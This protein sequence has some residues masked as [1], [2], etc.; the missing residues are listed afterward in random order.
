M[1]GLILCVA[2]LLAFS[3]SA[4]EDLH[5]VGVKAGLNLSRFNH[6]NGNESD[7]KPGFNI[8]LYVKAPIAK[9]MYIRPEIYFSGQGEKKDIKPDPAGLLAEHVV[10]VNYLNLPVLL[11]AG[12]K[13]T[14]Q[15]GPQLGYLLTARQTITVD[16]ETTRQSI[17][18]TVNRFDVSGVIGIGIN[19]HESFNAGMRLNYGITDVFKTDVSSSNHVFHVYFAYTF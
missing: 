11:E 13:V 9:H 19:P 2:T 10:T 6:D 8:G 1:R 16:D 5:L 17:K 12:K 18:S 15:A 14:I 4:Q 7:I 3:S